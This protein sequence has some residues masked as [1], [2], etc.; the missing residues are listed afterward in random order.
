MKIR[1]AAIAPHPPI[2]LPQVGSEK[3]RVKVKKT[4]DAL[5]KAAKIFEKEN[6]DHL[7]IS[8]P[9]PDWGFN[10]PLYFIAKNFKGGIKTYLTGL[11]N[12]DFYFEEGK[13]VYS[14]L[15]DKTYGLIASGDLSH[16]L[17]ED[18]PYGFHDQGPKFDKAL[19]DFLK[20]KDIASILKLD[21]MFP[22]AGECGL[23][24]FCRLSRKSHGNPSKGY[25]CKTSEI[26][27]LSG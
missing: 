11:E 23:G 3:D 19:I 24:S 9:H 22:E 4:L 1:F 25:P 17:K 5:E 7:I 8:S 15:E 6:P 10:V 16:R 20:K 2:L 14:Q 27:M 21:Q 18:G 12:P 13:K 26:R